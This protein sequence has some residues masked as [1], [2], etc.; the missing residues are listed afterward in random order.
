MMEIHDLTDIDLINIAANIRDIDRFEFEI[1]GGGAPLSESLAH[2]KAKSVRARAAYWDGQIVAAYG[3]LAPTALSFEGN[4]WLV[5]THA[6]NDRNVRREF[7]R[8][9]EQ[10]FTWLC[11]GFDHLWN[12]ISPKNTV[13][14]RW[15]RWLGFQFDE[16]AFE[17][18]GHPFLKFQMGD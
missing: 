9:T 7:I 2:M 3:L 5:S 10:E 11:Q 15:L 18:Q 14:I 6:L 4:P 1:M 13:A 12:I 16:Q 8:Y 17:I